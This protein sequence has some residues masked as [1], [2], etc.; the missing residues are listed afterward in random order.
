MKIKDESKKEIVV[1]YQIQVQEAIDKI[2]SRECNLSKSIKEYVKNLDENIK[3]AP[4]ILGYLEW[5]EN[6]LKKKKIIT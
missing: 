1:A 2:N 3:N 6:A 5:P 4:Y